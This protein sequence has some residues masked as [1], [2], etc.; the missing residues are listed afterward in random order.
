MELLGAMIL[1][2]T[3]LYKALESVREEDFYFDRHRKIFRAIRN[4]FERRSEISSISVKEELKRA[5]DLEAIGGVEY[6]ANIVESV[7]SPALVDEYIR[8]VVEK[9]IYRQIIDVTMEVLEKAYKESVPADELLDYAEHKI[10]EIRQKQLSQAFVR[11]GDMVQ[12]VFTMINDLILQRRHVTGVPTGFD[13][14]DH[15]TSGFQPGDLVIIASRPSMG[16]TSFALN[17]MRYLGVEKG[18]PSAI[19]SLEMSRE[20]LVMRL[21]SMESGVNSQALRTGFVSQD[22]IPDLTDAVHRLRDAPIYIDDTPSIHILE[23]K[24]KARRIVKE[25]GVKIL[26]VDYLQLVRGFRTESKVQEIAGISQALKA[27]AKELKIPV[28]ALSQ[29]SRAPEQRREDRR[30]RLSDLRESGSIE[31]DADVVL[32]IYRP[33]MYY[34]NP[35]FEGLAEIIIGKQRNGPVGTVKLAFL[36]DIMRF[37]PYAGYEAEEYVAGEE[38]F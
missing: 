9:A 19:F 17:I 1:Q 26:F 25:E 2:D 18:I 15:L 36:K 32:F 14:L 4:L 23:L 10:L 29:L 33:E 6:L 28:V 31:Q 22:R 16:K 5:G 3:A 8:I 13:E 30:P 12:D 35:E 37:E 11:V 27:L 7:I 21:L 20:Q 38:Y 34:R 24:A